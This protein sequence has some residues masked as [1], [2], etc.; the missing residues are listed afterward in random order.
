MPMDLGI[1]GCRAIVRASGREFERACTQALAA[2]GC[3]I[4]INGRDEEPLNATATAMH[5]GTAAETLRSGPDAS[6]QDPHIH[7]KAAPPFTETNSARNPRVLI[8]IN[9]LG[10]FHLLPNRY[11]LSPCRR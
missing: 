7:N 8:P 1:S 4:L 6:P 11:A 5:R 10:V 2:G 3:E 9:M